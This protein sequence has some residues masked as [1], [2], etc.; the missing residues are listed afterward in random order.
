MTHRQVFS[1]PLILK[2]LV[3][4][5]PRLMTNFYKSDFPIVHQIRM[6]HIKMT[7]LR[8]L[9]FIFALKLKRRLLHSGLAYLINKPDI[10]KTTVVEKRLPILVAFDK[11]ELL[12]KFVV[13]TK[14]RQRKQ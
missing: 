8:G 2:V 10:I 12:S 14:Q 1:G 13:S 6:A 4:N 7:R 9:E 5:S 11:P 3:T